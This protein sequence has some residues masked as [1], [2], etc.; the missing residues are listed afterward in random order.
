MLTGVWNPGDPLIGDLGDRGDGKLMVPSL[1]TMRLPFD[2]RWRSKLRLPPGGARTT[3]MADSDVVMLLWV[4]CN[5][6][7]EQ[8]DDALFF[9]CVPVNAG[10]A[11]KRLGG[12]IINELGGASGA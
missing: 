11:E 8:V 2:A 4:R 12:G 1:P 7:D 9:V 6:D 3:V 5:D 10:A